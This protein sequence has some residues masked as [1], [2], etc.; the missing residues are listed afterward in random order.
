MI[1]RR[2]GISPDGAGEVSVYWA[3]QTV[4]T[5]RIPTDTAGTEIFRSQHAASCHYS[6]EGIECW[7]RWILRIF[8]ASMLG[9]DENCNI[10]TM[11]LSN[12]AARA[13]ELDTSSVKPLRLCRISCNFSKFDR[14]GGRCR[15]KKDVCHR[16]VFQ[17]GKYFTLTQ[18][19]V[20][21]SPVSF[22]PR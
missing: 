10:P 15:L 19:S 2:T 14:G 4:M 18:L 13:P 17:M 22:A 7:F 12:E 21:K 5:K 11:H 9:S 6:N 20:G 16:E 3:G 1:I 8:G